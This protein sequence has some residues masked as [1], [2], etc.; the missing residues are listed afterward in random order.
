MP[1]AKLERLVDA[2]SEPIGLSDAANFLRLEVADDDDLV[3]S[4][5]TTARLECEQRTN[6]SFINTTWQL[7]LDYFPP[8]PIKT[9]NILP[10]LAFGVAAV[11]GRTL[12]LNMEM[13]AIR[14]PM[15]PLVSVTSISYVD[16]TGQA[17]SLPSPDVVI[18]T[19]TP[20]QIAPSFG[21]IFPL[22][23]PSLSSVTIDYVAGYGPDASFV[24]QAVKTA[25]LFLVSHYY[26]HRTGDEPE[27]AVIDS[28]LRTVEWCPY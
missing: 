9:T 16:P 23:I 24:P 3:Q 15:P 21:N 11:G 22:T 19:G 5:I 2:A 10:A 6:R 12:F 26:N 14:L 1:N 27:P 8:Y 13:G 18:S 25:M 17:R 7:S 4:L 20:G 28:L